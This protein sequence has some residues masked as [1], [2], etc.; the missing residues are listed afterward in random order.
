MT[1]IYQE[2]SLESALADLFSRTSADRTACDAKAKE[3]AG[4]NRVTPVEIQGVCS[5]TVYAGFHLQ[6]VVQF[7][8]DS[9]ALKSE[10]ALLAIEIYG[11]LAPDISFK[12]FVGDE[13]KDPLYVYLMNRVEGVSHLNFILE[14]GFPEDSPENVCW[15]KNLIADMARY[16]SSSIVSSAIL[17][18]S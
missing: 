5:Y 9:F 18:P 8:I 10:T 17:I 11:S 15:R 4:G 14:R 12:G 1:D 13:R 2:Y 7:R 6:Y 3:L 16:V